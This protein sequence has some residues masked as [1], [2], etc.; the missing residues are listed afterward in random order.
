MAVLQAAVSSS[1]QSPN[2]F[3]SLLYPPNNTAAVGEIRV[4]LCHDRP[5]GNPFAS[6]PDKEACTCEGPNQINC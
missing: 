2:G 4:K 5:Q 6:S 3:H 1:Q